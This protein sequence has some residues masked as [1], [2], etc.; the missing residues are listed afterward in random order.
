[1]SEKKTI[2]KKILFSLKII[3]SFSLLTYLLSKIEWQKSLLTI[4]NANFLWLTVAVILSM[5][6]NMLLTYKWNLLLKVRNK[7][8][9]FWRLLAINMIGGFWG[10][11]L[12]SSLSTDVVRGY[13]LVKT[14]SDKAISVT[15][16]FVDRLF[17]L[18][19]LLV[20]VSVALLFA[21]DILKD[22]HLGYYIFCFF[23][24]MGL[25]LIT[26]NSKRFAT[27]LQNFN[28]KFKDNRI[29]KNVIKLRSAVIEYNNYPL[30]LLLSFLLSLL[31][32]LFR[33]FWYITIAWSFGVHIPMVYYFIFCPLIIVVLMIPVSIGGFGVREGSFVALFTLA[34][35]SLD[36]A[37]IISFTSS[38]IANIATISGGV[39]YL[40]YRSEYKIKDSTS[41]IQLEVN[42]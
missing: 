23:V 39:V 18:L 17:A 40:F 34:G 13:Y 10:L 11:F 20:F 6:D 26:F 8:V 7:F 3:I 14:T 2:S 25:G 24:L 42:D 19:A 16:I 33:V 22:L 41:E 5:L 29:I 9:S 4:Q 1:M 21:G 37:V 32:Q 15:S 35:M 12:P 31:I 36:E 30:T 38:L 28:K 27:L